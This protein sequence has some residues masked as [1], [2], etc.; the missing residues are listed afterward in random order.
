MRGLYDIVQKRRPHPEN[1]RRRAAV[2]RGDPCPD[3]LARQDP[4]SAHEFHARQPYRDLFRDVPLPGHRARGGAGRDVGLFPRGV[5]ARGGAARAQPSGIRRAGRVRADKKTGDPRQCVRRFS[6]RAGDGRGS[7]RDGGRCGNGV[8]VLGYDDGGHV[9]LDRAGPC[10]RGHAGTQ[11]GGLLPRAAGLAARVP[12]GGADG[13]RLWH[14]KAVEPAQKIRRART[15][16]SI[17]TGA[18]QKRKPQGRG[19]ITK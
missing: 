4:D 1:V 2:R 19:Y 13:R 5:P 8:L 10:G 18:P 3:G 9:R 11:H 17:K 6:V 16:R 14:V 15:I 7:R 12:C